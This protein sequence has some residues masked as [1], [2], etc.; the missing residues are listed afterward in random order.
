MLTW[1]AESSFPDASVTLKMKPLGYHGLLFPFA[2][3]YTIVGD[4]IELSTWILALK[5]AVLLSTLLD[6]IIP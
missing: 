3:A 4:F 2:I 6:Y 5:F 1:D